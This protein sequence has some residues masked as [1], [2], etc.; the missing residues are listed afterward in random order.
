MIARRNKIISKIFCVFVLLIMAV[1]PNVSAT[2]QVEIYGYI[3]LD[4][5]NI[6]SQLPNYQIT[7]RDELTQIDYPVYSD[8]YGFFSL[9]LMEPQYA[10]Y[11]EYLTLTVSYYNS[12]DQNMIHGYTQIIMSP[13]MRCDPT[14]ELTTQQCEWYK[15]N[16]AS[17][18]IPS[19][20]SDEIVTDISFLQDYAFEG[21]SVNIFAD[22]KNIGDSDLMQPTTVRFYDVDASL[23]LGESIIQSPLVGET[24]TADIIW[25]CDL[26]GLRS[27]RAIVGE[28]KSFIDIRM[29]NNDYLRDFV[30]LTYTGD[31]DSDGLKNWDEVMVFNTDPLIFDSVVVMEHDWIVNYPMQCSDVTIILNGNL[32]IEPGNSLILNNINLKMDSSVSQRN[33][34][35]QNLGGLSASNTIISS[36][37]PENS[38][39]FSVHGEFILVNSKV[40]HMENGIQIDSNNAILSNSILSDSNIGIQIDDGSHP[41]ITIE[42][43]NFI[44]IVDFHMVLHNSDIQLLDTIFDHSKLELVSSTLTV[45]R[46]IHVRVFDSNDNPAENINVQIPEVSFSGYTNS[47][48]FVRNILLTDFII[49]DTE[50][51][52]YP[53]TISIP[54]GNIAFEG[55]E[56]NPDI[57]VRASDSLPS[58][59]AIFTLD[60]DPSTGWN[61][62]V[63]LESDYLEYDYANPTTIGTLT[64]DFISTGVIGATSIDAYL[65]STSEW[66]EVDT[67]EAALNPQER[68]IILHSIK[69][70]PL[71][72]LILNEPGLGWRFYSP[73]IFPQSGDP[74]HMPWQEDF[75]EVQIPVQGDPNDAHTWEFDVDGDGE[76]EAVLAP[77]AADLINELLDGINVHPDSTIKLVMP[78]QDPRTWYIWVVE[79]DGTEHKIYIWQNGARRPGPVVEAGIDNPSDFRTIW[80]KADPLDTKRYPF[81]N[82]PQSED[83]FPE[84]DISVSVNDDG[85]ITITITKDGVQSQYTI[86]P[87]DYEPKHGY[88]GVDDDG[89]YFID[90]E[91]NIYRPPD[92]YA[93]ETKEFLEDLLQQDGWTFIGQPSD[94][95]TWRWVDPN[96]NVWNIDYPEFADTL[97]DTDGD[98][99]PN[100]Y[101]QFY[102]FDI[103]GEDLD[104]D[105]KYNGPLDED[106]D[107][108]DFT[109]FEEIEVIFRTNANGN[110][111]EGTWVAVDVDGI[112]G[113]NGYSYTGETPITEE[114]KDFDGYTP[115]G[116]RYIILP[117]KALP[118]AI[119]IVIYPNI[120][121]YEDRTDRA[122]WEL[123]PLPAG[124]FYYR[125]TKRVGTD[126]IKEDTDGDDL[127]DF[128]EYNSYYSVRFY[129]MGVAPRSIGDP[130]ANSLMIDWAEDTHSNF[131]LVTANFAITHSNHDELY[132]QLSVTDNEN[133]YG[134]W[135]LCVRDR[136]ELYK[137]PSNIRGNTYEFSIDISDYLDPYFYFRESFPLWIVSVD[138]NVGGNAGTIDYFY[139]ETVGGTDPLIR[140]MDSDGSVDG[141]E[142]SNSYLK[143]FY[144]LFNAPKNIPDPGGASLY[145][146]DTEMENSGILISAKA[147]F[148]VTH[149]DHNELDIQLSLAEC[150]EI[151]FEG[152]VLNTRLGSTIYVWPSS[153]NGNSHKYS[154]ELLDYIDREVVF[155]K[156]ISSFWTL[157]V[158]DNYGGNAGTLDYF[159][160]K[161]TAKT[162][163]YDWDS[164]NDRL[165][166]GDEA[167]Y[168]SNPFIEDTDGDTLI[169]YDEVKIYGTPPGDFDWDGDGLSDREV[170]YMDDQNSDGISDF[171]PNRPGD[172]PNGDF[173]GDTLSNAVELNT[174]YTAPNR[175]DTDGDHM[176]DDRDKQPCNYNRRFAFIF[177]VS[178]FP[179]SPDLSEHEGFNVAESLAQIDFDLIYLVTDNDYSDEIDFECTYV[180]YEDLAYEW[181]YE[182][183]IDNFKS[184]TLDTSENKDGDDIVVVYM[185]SHGIATPPI[186]DPSITLYEFLLAWSITCIDEG[187]I[188]TQMD[189]LGDALDLLWISTCESQ[190]AFDQWGLGDEL[191]VIGNSGDNDGGSSK[192]DAAFTGY[193]NGQNNIGFGEGN[194]VENAFSFADEEEEG[195]DLEIEDNYSGELYLI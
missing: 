99:I 72:R 150:P 102:F 15:D 1:I 16:E 141:S 187:N 14:F 105:G 42:N 159:R 121:K 140:D 33:I 91:G 56:T 32:I 157:L 98:K 182:D 125:E 47:I 164:E 67:F 46:N 74:V 66:V 137:S 61:R 27:V 57:S 92:A 156:K 184:C 75:E 13:F 8:Q 89:Y 118:L 109:D 17:P 148:S 130:G 115:E 96:G 43:C 144:P 173:D 95:S 69:G 63:N 11:N 94:P 64:L 131:Y 103:L 186:G 23:L 194:S 158:Y 149:P 34:I 129:H 53:H 146:T 134:D 93:G 85:T 82:V 44:N 101:E 3:H 24:T 133:G 12:D 31:Y 88:I 83:I 135:M 104:G 77:W 120:V 171:D 4:D 100:L 48:G 79:P 78:S 112:G 132:I 29:D 26:T 9:S 152:W 38:Y 161:Y 126:P 110:Y 122:D 160:I 107:G 49:T 162:N 163:P 180:W 5:G 127:N 165:D 59:P 111:V 113:L 172:D 36:N 7:I 2:T 178:D 123:S 45:K 19:P 22:V 20:H 41:S 170:L 73:L 68:I 153:M 60:G 151:D 175:V 21:D 117:F 166:D 37:N 142:L 189:K 192:W 71:S 195:H 51:T 80:W 81:Q 116:Y 114:P 18:F 50:T 25:V 190:H 167:Q 52:Y 65:Y 169:D 155:R 177:E 139:I 188:R 179:I 54:S 58:N 174:K 28:E 90:R 143:T 76:Y 181:T 84:G 191:I 136:Q 168:G 138:D 35:I 124:N 55:Y 185:T 193:V 108:D 40:S 128:D 154:I 30:V 176:R 97:T 70:E 62:E 39:L 10:I 106:T 183:E 145:I 119:Y 147:E 87:D 86:N 6:V